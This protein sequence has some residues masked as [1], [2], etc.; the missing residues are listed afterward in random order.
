M[1][2]GDLETA[3]MPHDRLRRNMWNA[4]VIYSRIYR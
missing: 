3:L 1:A 4:F 2:G